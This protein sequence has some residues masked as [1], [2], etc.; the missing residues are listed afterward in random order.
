MCSENLSHH[1]TFVTF[2]LSIREREEIE[3][4][5]QL[6]IICRQFFSLSLSLYPLDF[7]FFKKNNGVSVMGYQI[8]AHAFPIP[9]ILF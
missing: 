3:L 2:L 9:K 8:Y 5:T 1:P 4:L 7:F 6:V